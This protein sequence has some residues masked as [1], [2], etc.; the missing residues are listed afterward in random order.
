MTNSEKF[1]ERYR[2][3]AFFAFAIIL[4]ILSYRLLSYSLFYST[5]QPVYSFE[6]NELWYRF[7]LSTHLSQFIT[8]S[9]WLSASF[10]SLLILFPVLF[11]LTGKRIFAIVFSMFLLFYFL[12]YNLIT[13]HHYHGL[14]GAIIIS[15]PFWTKNE[16]RFNLL[17]EAARYYL[18]YIFASAAL[19]K[20]LRGSAFYTDQ[21][22]NI[23]KSQ[24]LDL[25]LQQPDSFQA[26][27]VQYLIA[28]PEASHWVL[29]A[30][31][32]VQ[33]SFLVGFFTKKFDAA[34]FVIS[35]VFC[36]ANYFVMS[37]VSAELLIL[38]LTLLNWD[39]IVVGQRPTTAWLYRKLKA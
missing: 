9:I 4:L 13:G 37:I 11:L 23:L 35:I 38:N 1:N 12:T 15:I 7:F 25:L 33:L 36:A 16:T 18:L 27:V 14:V 29:L 30:N 19:W 31:V 34:L 24:Q 3:K 5:S 21:L 17:W 22:S 6:E 20:I 2:L 28:N 10:D 39:K 8:D 32:F 26:H